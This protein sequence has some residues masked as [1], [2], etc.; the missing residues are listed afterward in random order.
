MI[1]CVLA[2]FLG[3]S[4]VVKA[5]VTIGM[6]SDPQTGALLEL[7]EKKEAATARGEANA[8][9]GLLFPRVNLVSYDALTPLNTNPSDEE[10]KE[11][12][13][14]VVYNV[15]AGA[16][17]VDVGLNQ[18]NG[19][20]WQPLQ[21]GIVRKAA[22]NGI[23]SNVVV[24]GTYVEGVML[25]P[26]R[27]SLKVQVDV[28][29]PGSYR[30]TAATTNGYSFSANGEFNTT[31]TISITL[32]GQ[33]MPV[34]AG[35]DN[36]T[37]TINDLS[38]QY[39]NLI[40][41]VKVSSMFSYECSTITTTTN[42]KKDVAVTPA[43]V[44]AVP[45]TAYNTGSALAEY[46]IY[47]DEV[48]GVRFEA[49][50]T[51]TAGNPTITLYASGTPVATGNFVY[52][53]HSNSSLMTEPCRVV[54][55]TTGSTFNLVVR[56]SNDSWNIYDS[57]SSLYAMAKNS[58]FFSP[59]LSSLRQIDAFNISGD[60][61]TSLS[62]SDLNGDMIIW[63]YTVNPSNSLNDLV[64]FCKA[65]KPVVVELDY[66]YMDYLQDIANAMHNE[67]ITVTYLASPNNNL[68]LVADNGNP[69]VKG[70]YM[71]LTGK[72]I[73][74]DG[75]GNFSFSGYSPANWWV[76]AQD[77][78]GNAR[79]IMNKLYPLI[80]IGDGGLLSGRTNSNDIEYRPVRTS[81]AVPLAHSYRGGTV[82]N[83]HFLLNILLWGVD[84]K[85]N[86]L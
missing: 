5:Q 33:G 70:S 49:K 71:D 46:H 65:G 11:A 42:L 56:S 61:S 52:T 13:G 32:L 84:Q 69:I 31:G 74:L 53:I 41:V 62:A 38:F 58:N 75:Y 54:I 26:Y 78:S 82:H 36:V 22:V 57:G 35:T 59:T 18:W 10:K 85:N 15:N 45:I 44:I 9:K 80:L 7:R 39:P 14:M 67:S 4:V 3:I 1:Y 43:D 12:T 6:L 51:L 25:D 8:E 55:P 48:N 23:G 16:N 24:D 20:E 81:N 17:G 50:G 37:I 64:D 73:G 68:S 2:F 28:Q 86:I 27:N 21:G 77:A 66:G 63:S 79:I 83:A 76:I 72:F 30:I 60:N 40:T 29:M 34:A 19:V 47:T